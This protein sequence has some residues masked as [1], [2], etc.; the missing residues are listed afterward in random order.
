MAGAV[1]TPHGSGGVSSADLAAAPAT[2]PAPQVA[3]VYFA[4]VAELAGRRDD[5]YDGELPVQGSQLLAWLERRH[6][7][8]APA[9]RLQL[10]INQQHA[11]ADAW[12]RPG[13]EVAVFEPVTGG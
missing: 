8:L 12:V 13:D 4:Q 1:A 5:I 6:P 11:R 2:R 7:A 3:L 9:S 10:A